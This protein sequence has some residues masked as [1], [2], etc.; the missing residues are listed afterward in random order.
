MHP[1]TPPTDHKT[2]AAIYQEKL[3]FC[4]FIK[5]CECRFKYAV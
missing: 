1:S 2:A 3:P 4:R 5:Y